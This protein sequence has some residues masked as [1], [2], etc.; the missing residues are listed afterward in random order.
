MMTNGLRLAASR[1]RGNARLDR[2]LQ[3]SAPSVDAGPALTRSAPLRKSVGRPD[4]GLTP[5]NAGSPVSACAS[6][7]PSLVMCGGE[8]VRADPLASRRSLARLNVLGRRS[9]DAVFGS[10]LGG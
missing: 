9:V 7:G 6:F 4:V 1:P 8:C 2:R 10:R 3:A 5:V